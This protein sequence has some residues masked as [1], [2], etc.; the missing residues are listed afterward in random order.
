MRSVSATCASMRKRRVAAG[1]D[2]PQAIVG[3]LGRVVVRLLD[4][5]DSIRT[6]T[7]DFS[8]SSNCARR[9]IR[10]MALCR[11]VWMIQAAR[12]FGDAGGPPLVHRGRKCF[13]R[14]LFGQVEVTEET[15]QCRD[16]PAPIGAINCLNRC[17]CFHETC[18]IVN[19]FWR[20]VDPARSAIRPSDGRSNT[21]ANS[22]IVSFSENLRS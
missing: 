18:P 2:Q 7:Y 22:Q 21:A 11:A 4:V 16:D 17:V 1:E 15:N 3:D 8:F 19:I 9:R 14:S 5:R 20:S 10:S 12:R 13:L 6:A